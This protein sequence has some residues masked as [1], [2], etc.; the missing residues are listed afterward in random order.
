M[1]L[2]IA[3]MGHPVLQR[4]ADEVRVEDILSPSIQKLIS[5]MIET[6]HALNG[7]GL[8]APQ[9]FQ[10]LRIVIFHIP[11]ERAIARGLQKEIPLTVLINP[12]IEPL[13]DETELGWE[14]CFS[15][16]GLM[17]LV[18][19]YR[20]IRYHAYNAQ[21]HQV[22]VEVEG[23]HARVVQHECDHLDGILYPVRMSDMNQFGF[24]EEV[25]EALS[26]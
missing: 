21:G 19:R 16:P 13:T 5:D 8:A 23:Y 26:S 1:V 22:E 3:R 9:V 2:E 18:P 12:V 6:C 7:A 20:A 11:E 24:I 14:A 15:L 25:R 10:P 17:G 4:R